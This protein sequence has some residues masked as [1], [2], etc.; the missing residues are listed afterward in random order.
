MKLGLDTFSV[1]NKAAIYDFFS[2]CST[3]PFGWLI[4]LGIADSFFVTNKAEVLIELVGCSTR[5]L[6]PNIID[7]LVSIFLCTIDDDDDDD[8]DDDNDDDDDDDQDDF[9]CFCLNTRST[10]PFGWL[11]K[12]G[13]I[14]IPKGIL[15]TDER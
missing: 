1:S 7:V 5:R 15:V 2:T 8:D 4:K 14:A 12:L 11:I 13:R 3:I 6:L 10:I 9:D